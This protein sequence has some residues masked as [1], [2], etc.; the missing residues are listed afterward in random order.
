M[1]NGRPE[2]AIVDDDEPVQRALGRLLV[3][4]DFDVKAFA[5][6]QAFLDSLSDELPDCVV[7]DLYM[8][9][10]SGLDVFGALNRAGFKLPVIM[11]T[12]RDNPDSRAKSLAAGV[13]DYLTK[14]IDE[15]A[16]L[17]A[18]CN[19]VAGSPSARIGPTHPRKGTAPG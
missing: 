6:G 17:K 4:W 2:I 13:V 9:G 16:L 12:G 1:A 7:L 8:L 5:S 18:V 3:A 10:L 14:P 15:V 11:I 19:A